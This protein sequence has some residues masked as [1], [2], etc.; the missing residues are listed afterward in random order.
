ML[1]S[2]TW[3]DALVYCN[4]R[5]IAEGRTLSYTICDSTWQYH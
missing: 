1:E 2:I 5:S 3:F 4:N